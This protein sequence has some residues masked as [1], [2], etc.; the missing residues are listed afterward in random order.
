MIIV[1]DTVTA[2]ARALGIPVPNKLIKEDA[3]LQ[4]LVRTICSM[5][6]V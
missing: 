4:G 6:N 2:T 5:E 3:Q 1:D